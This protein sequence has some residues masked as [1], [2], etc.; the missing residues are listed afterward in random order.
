MVFEK[1]INRTS[2]NGK[3]GLEINEELTFQQE[4]SKKFYVRCRL[5]I[6]ILDPQDWRVEFD[7]IKLVTT[8][9]MF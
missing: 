6:W 1:Y 5:N 4:L 8:S 3:T 9:M 7:S 2:F